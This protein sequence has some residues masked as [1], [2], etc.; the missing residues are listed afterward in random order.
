MAGLISWVPR[1][2]E[3]REK[4]KKEQIELVRTMGREFRYRGGLSPPI[5]PASLRDEFIRL[6]VLSVF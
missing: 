2:P 4:A 5:P 1:P 3:E 6:I